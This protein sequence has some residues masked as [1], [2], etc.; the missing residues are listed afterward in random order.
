MACNCDNLSVLAYA[1]GF[2]LWHYTTPD[3]A[4]SLAGDGYFDAAADMLRAGDMLL[5]NTATGGTASAGLF[6]VGSVS[7]GSVGVGNA[8]PAAKKA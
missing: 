3:S 1:N 4:A 8:F 6:H 7:G 5:A 2:T